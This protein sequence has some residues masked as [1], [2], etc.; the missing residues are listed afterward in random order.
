MSGSEQ[1]SPQTHQGKEMSQLSFVSLWY[2]F[3]SDPSSTLVLYSS[4]LPFA[5]P[6]P[7]CYDF[8]G[9][10]FQAVQVEHSGLLTTSQDILEMHDVLSDPC[11]T[12]SA[13][14]HM[15]KLFLVVHM[16]GLK[17]ICIDLF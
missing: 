8:R 14:L 13:V 3:C 10:G 7:L 6:K 17:Y 5:T 12:G 4:L 9:S 15:Q 2:P 11:V 16:A 1:Q